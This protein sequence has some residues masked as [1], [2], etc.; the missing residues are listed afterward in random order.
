M[1]YIGREPLN[2]L[3]TK[4]IIS[5]DSSTT[6]FAL[7]FGIPSTTAI[8]VSVN[9]VILQPDVGYTISGGGT[10]IVFASAPSAT[11]YIH[12]LDNQL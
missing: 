1:A 10:S 12:Y 2:G 6:T 7:D 3:L 4:Q 9:A 11:T 8:I 5:H